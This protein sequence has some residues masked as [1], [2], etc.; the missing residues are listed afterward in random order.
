MSSAKPDDWENTK[1][2]LMNPNPISKNR[3]WLGHHIEK[4]SG[5]IDL[6]VLQG[7]FSIKEIAEGRN[8]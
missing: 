7:K 8:I 5:T 2:Q 1:K 3:T 6:M 4:Q